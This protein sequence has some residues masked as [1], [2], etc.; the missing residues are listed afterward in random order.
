MHR[1]VT[2]RSPT[3]SLSEQDSAAVPLHLQ[4]PTDPTVLP[5]VRVGLSAWAA[6]AGLGDHEVEGLVLATYEAVANSI[7]HGYRD[8]EEGTIT[9]LTWRTTDR[10]LVVEVSDHG[11][12]RPPPPGPTTRGQGIPLM[13]A[14]ADKVDIDHDVNGTTVRLQWPLPRA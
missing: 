12:W 1:D 3:H 6:Q 9:V 7:E 10:R 13:R 5:K 8:H 11:Q 14:L 2:D 4:I